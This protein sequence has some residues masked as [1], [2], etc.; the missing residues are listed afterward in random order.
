MTIA[1]L[2]IPWLALHYLACVMAEGTLR[3][4]GSPGTKAA[5][6]LGAANATVNQLVQVCISWQFDWH[7]LKLSDC[8]IGTCEQKQDA[9][10]R[11]YQIV[12]WSKY[13]YSS[14]IPLKMS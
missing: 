8:R 10:H 1:L 11:W 6:F 2:D 12:S 7:E 9:N 3:C 4:P 5:C 14:I 13:P